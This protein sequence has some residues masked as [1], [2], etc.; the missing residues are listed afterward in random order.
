MD[1]PRPDIDAVHGQPQGAPPGPLP[2]RLLAPLMGD[3]VGADDLVVLPAQRAGTNTAGRL[4]RGIQE[5]GTSV[6]R[7]G[8][9]GRA[10]AAPR[11]G[12]QQP[13]QRLEE[14]GDSVTRVVNSVGCR[15]KG[16]ALRSAPLTE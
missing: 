16:I 9:G 1:E 12:E 14:A 11:A 5:G 13:Q 6:R 4:T 8:D 2:P 7:S 15:P 3:E 10:T